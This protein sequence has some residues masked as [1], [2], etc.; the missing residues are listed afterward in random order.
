MRILFLNQYFHP[1]ASATSQLLTELCEDLAEQHDV[2]VVTGRPSYN[3][4]EESPSRGLVSRENHGGVHVAR[5]WSTS[6]DRASML[7]RLANYLSYLATSVL[8]VLSVPKP[9]VIVS[10]TD[11]PPIGLIGAAA[12]KLQRAPFV[13]VTKDIVPEAVVNA[14]KLSNPAAIRVLSATSNLLY[15]AADRVV[16]IGRD[17]NRRL[18]ELGVDPSK[19]V[20]INDWSDGSLVRPLN[21]SSP[22]RK[23]NAWTDQFVVMHSGNLG[24]GQ[25]LNVIIEAA[26]LLRDHED[27]VIAFVGEGAS[28]RE[29]QA[30]SDRRGLV[31]VVFLPFQP[32][33]RLAESLGAADV[34]LVTHKRGMAGYQVPS[35]LYGILAA[36]KPVIAAVEPESEPAMIIEEHSCG[37]RVD[38]DDAKELAAAILEMRGQRLVELGARSR[39]AFEAAYERT[40]QTAAYRKLLEE[41]ASGS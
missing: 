25:S 36:G 14:G 19:I 21:G 37:V 18:E 9:D 7:G 41:V 32:K 6:M 35:K 39:K 5:V 20:T 22:F 38:P 11:P 27:I 1:D 3:A 30:A 16:S 8:G 23:E 40:G 4:A 2:W 28:K 33:E 13:L 34:H 29:L 31:N 17:M 24:F 15:R 10:L 26:D 12:A